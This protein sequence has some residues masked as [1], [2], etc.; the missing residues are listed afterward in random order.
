[1]MNEMQHPTAERLEA[2]VEGILD[3]GDRAVVESHLMG[4][5]HCQSAVEE[6]RALFAA[7]EGLPH[8][9]PAPGFADRVMADV[10][11]APAGARAAG[12]S[13]QSAQTAVMA[14]AGDAGRAASRLMP[15]TTFGWAMATAFLSLPV[16]L[17][18]AAMGWLIS[19]EYITAQSLWV[20][21]TGQAAAGL[22]SL[23]ETAV[24]TALQTDVAAWLV[25]QTGQFMGSAGLTGV[26]LVLAAAGTA[27][28]LSAWVLY[29]N[30]FRTP[31]RDTTY[32]SYSF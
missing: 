6:W 26:G 14:W 11:V 25:S 17:G 13:W 21:A 18:A 9:E 29:R 16:V 27:T 7:L 5:S 4:C 28:A 22:R 3:A 20:F 32:A 19:R 10:K 2:F 8:F 24:A 23:G 1:M 31:A 12:W 30:L 15:K